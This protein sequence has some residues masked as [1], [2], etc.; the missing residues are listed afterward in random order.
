MSLKVLKNTSFYMFSSFLPV[1]V[2]FVMLPIYA[3]FLTPAD[4]GVVAL[5]ISLQSFL[6]IVMTFQIH[7]PIS[8][9]YFEYKDNS[10]Q[11]KSYISTLLL[12][13]FVV[14][15]IALVIIIGFI[16]DIISLAFPKTVGY[17]ELFI[18]GVLVSY[19]TVYT[20]F[21]ILLLKAKQKAKFF[22]I[23]SIIT[24]FIS[25]IVNIIEIIVLKMGA[26]G[27]IEASLIVS[28]ISFLFYVPT[29]KNYITTKIDFNIIRDSVSYS[30]PLIPHSLSGLIFMYSDR[31]ILEKYVSIT[32]IG[33]YTF[34]DRIA[35]MLKKAL[36][37][38]NSAFSPYFKEVATSSK[39]LAIKEVKKFSSVIN[40]FLVMIVVIISLFSVE[41][42]FTFLNVKYFSTWKIIPL[43]SSVYVFRSLYSFSSGGLFFEK[44][45]GRVALITILAGVSNIV[46]NILFIP[47][48]GIM[49]AVYSTIFAFFLTY[50]LAEILSYKVYYMNLGII[51]NF[52]LIVYMYLAVFLSFKIN[53]D[54]PGLGVLDYF[55]KFIILLVGIIIGYKQRV[56]ND[57]FF[58]Q[59]KGI[60]KS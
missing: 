8:R 47:K 13:T 23:I 3:R 22:M 35:V 41:L 31:I 49:A 36:G 29:L 55:Y 10:A 33:L 30:L 19:I 51:K 27:I 40:Y 43:L 18:K 2:G 45:T 25:L 58:K 59:L 44:K 1:I 39:E 5:V 56:I 17:N 11:L 15:T 21:A 4:Y 6:P 28:I 54:F 52:V 12:T 37:E 7:K 50:V 34:S 20:T 38:F 26:V 53:E 48:Y 60:I 46:L 24:F 32:A 9:F 16:D 42:V 14:S 57:N